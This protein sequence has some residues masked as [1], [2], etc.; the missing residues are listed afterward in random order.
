M[1]AG[2]AVVRFEFDEE[3]VVVEGVLLGAGFEFGEVDSVFLERVEEF[4]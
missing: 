4:D 3:N 2:L 1:G